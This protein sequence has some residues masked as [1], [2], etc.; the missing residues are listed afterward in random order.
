MPAPYCANRQCRSS[1]RLL[2]D[3]GALAIGT[4]AEVQI[5]SR[6]TQSGSLLPAAAVTRDSSGN[7]VV[8]AHTGAEILPAARQAGTGAFRVK[9]LSAACR[10]MRASSCAA[11][12]CWRRYAEEAAMFNRIVSGSLQQR[13]LVLASALVL[14]LYGLWVVPELKVDVFP[15]LNKPIVTIM[16]EAEGY[17]PGGSRATG[18]AA[19]GG[20]NNGLPGV[21]WCARHRPSGCRS[22]ISNS[23]GAADPFRN[24]QLVTERLSTLNRQLCRE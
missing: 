21:S 3:T 11:P 24:R 18:H 15:D 5:H 13:L 16:T 1:S 19:A 7:Q 17:A 10:S 12:N 4:Q 8:W 22:C 14:I 2:G 23:T 6:Q 9:S 20:S